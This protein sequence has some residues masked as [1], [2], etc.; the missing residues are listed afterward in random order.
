VQ[1]IEQRED[2]M[3]SHLRD[4]EDVQL[5]T[6]EANKMRVLKHQGKLIARVHPYARTLTTRDSQHTVHQK[7]N[8][9]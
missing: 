3:L 7:I 8:F 1:E 2:L 4:V 5:R 9:F 6:R